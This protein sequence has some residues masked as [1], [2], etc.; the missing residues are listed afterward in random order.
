MENF[1]SGGGFQ[2]IRPL[3]GGAGIRGPP[4][5]GVFPDRFSERRRAPVI[6]NEARIV[7][8]AAVAEVA[9]DENLRHLP[10]RRLTLARS[11]LL[12]V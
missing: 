11:L 2:K 12:L 9:A 5:Q 3:L 6:N 10:P 4:P 1:L 7:A 8:V